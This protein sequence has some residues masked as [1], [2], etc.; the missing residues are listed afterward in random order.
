MKNRKII[1]VSVLALIA[2]VFF[3]IF[4]DDENTSTE[5]KEISKQTESPIKPVEDKTLKSNNKKND[6]K[7]ADN[8]KPKGDYFVSDDIYK[9][10]ERQ[11]KW[12]LK[13]IR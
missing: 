2:I 13:K 1:I 11:L 4:S 10:D 7:K 9:W 3:M 8:E 6:S 5:N 12:V